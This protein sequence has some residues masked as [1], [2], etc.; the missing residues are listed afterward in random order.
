MFIVVP[1]IPSLVVG[2]SR[3]R[4][5]DGHHRRRHPRPAV[6]AHQLRRAGRCSAGPGSARGR[7]SSLLLN[8]LARALPLLLLFSTFLFINAEAW[9]VAGT[10][11]GVVYV[12]VLGDLLPAR[13]DVRADPDPAADALAQPRST[14]WREV[15][16]LAAATPAATVLDEPAPSRSTQDPHADRPTVRQRVNIGLLTIFSQAIQ[17]TLVG[18]RPHRRSSSLFGFLAIPEATALAWT[19][20][21]D[22]DVL[23]RWHVG[24][25]D[26]RRSPSRCCASPASSAPSAAMYFT[27]L[28]S[29]DALY[30]EEFAD[31]VGPQLRQALAVRCVYRAARAAWTETLS[32]RGDGRHGASLEIR[33]LDDPVECGGVPRRCSTRCGARPRRSSAW[34]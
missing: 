23:V 22:V 21:D 16:E 4:A 30:R 20:L 2:Q 3:R 7:S 33:L 9:Q 10:L 31:D 15:A 13:G 1:A 17:I 5:A 19:A 27:V 11:T 24:G 34:S 14:S 12:A 25:R 26:A 8:V 29:T 28:L 18:A 32:R 6:G